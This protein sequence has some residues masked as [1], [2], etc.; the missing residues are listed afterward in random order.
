MGEQ[1][2]T[3]TLVSDCRESE[4]RTEPTFD[5]SS[6]D[7]RCCSNL[8]KEEEIKEAMV[9]RLRTD[10]DDFNEDE[11]DDEYDLFEEANLGSEFYP[12]RFTPSRP[13]GGRE[14]AAPAEAGIYEIVPPTTSSR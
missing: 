7:C 3:N 12:G 10:F 11:D 13:F 2:S 1:G 4:P 5:G 9:S 8:N 14:A 6:S